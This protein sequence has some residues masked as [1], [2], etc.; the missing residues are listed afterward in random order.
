MV[1]V[2]I[3]LSLKSGGL[4]PSWNTTTKM[5]KVETEGIVPLAEFQ[6]IYPSITAYLVRRGAEVYHTVIRKGG[7]HPRLV[8]CSSQ[9]SHIKTNNHAHL[10]SSTVA[11]KSVHTPWTFPHFVMVRPPEFY[12]KD[13]HKVIHNGENKKTEKCSEQKYSAPFFSECNQL[14]SEIARWYWMIKCWLNDKIESKCV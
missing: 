11:G 6:F 13:Q 2:K 3:L 9:S 4:V 8:P 5:C 7:L 1:N 12:V 14:P 10:H